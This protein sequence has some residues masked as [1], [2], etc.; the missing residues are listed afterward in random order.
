[1]DESGDV[2]MQTDGLDESSFPSDGVRPAQGRHAA[3]PSS[4][5][6]MP[7]MMSDGPVPH[8]APPKKRR[9]VVTH[10]QYMNLQSLVVLHLSEIERETG[11]GVDRDELIDWYLE[12]KEGEVQDVDELE[13]ERELITKMLKKLVRVSLFFLMVLLEAVRVIDCDSI[14]FS[15]V[16]G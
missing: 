8:A 2:Q 6:G 10:D 16:G 14:F 9:M 15:S 1:M 13:Y 12:L 3:A 4:S 11:R 5:A 7:G